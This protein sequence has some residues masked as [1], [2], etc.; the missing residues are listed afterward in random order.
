MIEINVLEES[1]HY[2]AFPV[3]IWCWLLNQVDRTE[4]VNNINRCFSNIYCLIFFLVW[5][6]FWTIKEIPISGKKGKKTVSVAML[7]EISIIEPGKWNTLYRRIYV[8]VPSLWDISMGI[9]GLADCRG[10]IIKLC[11]IQCIAFTDLTTSS[12]R[13][14]FFKWMTNEKDHHDGVVPFSLLNQKPKIQKRKIT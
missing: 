10:K 3:S 12:W 2:L 5:V 14:L 13:S 7:I 6:W 9:V 4:N 8:W 1:F 11:P